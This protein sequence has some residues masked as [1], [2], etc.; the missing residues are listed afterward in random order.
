MEGGK[1]LP[2][3]RVYSPTGGR[4]MMGRYFLPEGGGAY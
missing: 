4:L 1:V 2:E 3:S